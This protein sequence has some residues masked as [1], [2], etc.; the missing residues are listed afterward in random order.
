ML[1]TVK[2]YYNFYL[3]GVT[4]GHRIIGTP[5]LELIKLYTVADVHGIHLVISQKEI[6]IV[7]AFHKRLDYDDF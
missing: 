1:C 4:A 5:F 3:Q 7:L 6:I 2:L